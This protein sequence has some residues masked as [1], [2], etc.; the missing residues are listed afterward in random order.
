MSDTSSSIARLKADWFHFHDLDRARAVAQ[1]RRSG[2]SINKIALGLG[3]S[4]TLLRHLLQALQA[5]AEDQKLARQNKISTRELVRRA[6]EAE[7]HRAEQHRQVVELERAEASRQAAD[8]I[9]NWLLQTGLHGPSCEMIVSE[10][11][12]QFAWAEHVGAIPESKAHNLSVD[13]IIRRYQPPAL[14]NDSIDIIAWYALWLTQWV[15]WAFQD[16]CVRWTA[17]DLALTRQSRR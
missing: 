2:L 13:E 10:T 14:T 4:A 16:S 15:L 7:A 9:C 5:P 12:R 3:F 6:E 17:L 1:L 11:R 8:R